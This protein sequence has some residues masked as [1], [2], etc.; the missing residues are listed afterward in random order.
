MGTPAQTGQPAGTEI[1]GVAKPLESG[2]TTFSISTGYGKAPEVFVSGEGRLARP[3]FDTRL[4]ASIGFDDNIFQTPTDPQGTPDVVLRQQVTAGTE[5]QVVLIPVRDRRPV[6]IGVI[7]TPPRTQQ[8]RRVVIP[9]TEPTFQDIVIPGTP[10]PTREM[11]AI[12][13]ETLTFEAQTATRRSVF[14]FDLTANADYYWNRP[15]N[16]K[17][18]YNGSM[19]I[20]YLHRFTPRLQVTASADVSYL[21]QPDLAQINTPR[22]TGVGNYWVTNTKVDLS[23]RWT[24]R[25]TTVL[26]GSYN[27]LDYQEGTQQAGNYWQTT[28][29]LELR[30]LWSP[31]MAMVLEGRWAHIGYPENPA[32]DSTSYYAL[33]GVDLNLSRRAGITVR[34]GEAL[35]TFDESGNS[36]SAPYL[37][38]TLNYQL[39][40]ASVLSW[41]NRFGF[42]EPP[43]PNTEVL[44]FRTGLTVTHFFTPRLR[45]S[46]GING[47][48][49]VTSNNVSNIDST[50]ITLDSGLSFLYTLTR[51]W[52]LNLSYNYTTVFF[53]PNDTSNYFRDRIFAGFDYS[54]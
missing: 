54:F 32:L 28:F 36:S 23:Y 27:R 49:R 18:E 9:G 17:A 45:G 24:P 41:N 26:S 11:S 15:G 5:A 25:F 29:G 34:V 22:D 2:P 4:S 44:S 8:F 46:L 38:T 12:S 47:I 48:Y 7:T 16:D 20:R 51:K 37:E 6:R 39:G 53:D 31:K 42:E 35:R 13:R 19:A 43:D 21:S 52:T 40:K 30:Y 3:R 14:T 10:A 50:D 1:P 33:L